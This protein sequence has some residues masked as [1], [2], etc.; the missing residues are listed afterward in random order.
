MHDDMYDVNDP[1]S[2]TEELCSGC[3]RKCMSYTLI[4]KRIP[5]FRGF[6]KIKFHLRSI[7]HLLLVFLSRFYFLK[8]TYSIFEEFSMKEEEQRTCSQC[9]GPMKHYTGT[10]GTEK[11]VCI[12]YG[13]NY[14]EDTV[15]VNKP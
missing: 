15:Y 3:H 14:H 5:E 10:D 2:Y 9:G 1:L 7:T 4:G 6:R 13:T 8:H 12:N 11:Y